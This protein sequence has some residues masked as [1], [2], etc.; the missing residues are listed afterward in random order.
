MGFASYHQ[1]LLA[2]P[3]IAR[4]LPSSALFPDLTCDKDQLGDKFL[5]VG[6]VC[7]TSGQGMK[8]VGPPP[9]ALSLSCGLVLALTL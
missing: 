5:T 3:S 4:W 6:V 9:L 2:Q 8:T 7:E 1:C